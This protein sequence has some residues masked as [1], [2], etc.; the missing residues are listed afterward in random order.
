MLP[1]I[2]LPSSDL[3]L[4]VGHGDGALVHVGHQGLQHVH[5]NIIEDEHRVTAGVVLRLPVQ[6]II[7]KCYFL[8]R[9]VDPDP[10]SFSLLDPDPDP[11]PG[12]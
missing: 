4:V 6:V 10:H 5:V 12:G 1:P 8:S 9:A 2:P 3:E 11:G 7:K